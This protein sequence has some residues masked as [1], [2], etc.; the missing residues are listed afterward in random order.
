M[1]K[2]G[3]I[4]QSRLPGMRLPTFDKPRIISCSGETAEYLVWYGSVN[5]LSFGSAEESI[6]RLES[7]NIANELIR[8]MKKETDYG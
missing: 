8:S 3:K 5:L 6:M 7:S 4:K 2:G 1:Q